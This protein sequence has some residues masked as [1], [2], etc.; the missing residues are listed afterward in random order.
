MKK[1]VIVSLADANYYPLL[2][3]LIESI[4]QF[5]QSKDVAICILDAGLE[6]K[7]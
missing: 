6:P 7:Q 2:D 1:N 3:E 5:Q 4:K